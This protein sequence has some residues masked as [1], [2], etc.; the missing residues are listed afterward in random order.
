MNWKSKR[1][2]KKF[3]LHLEKKFSSYLVDLRFQKK[4]LVSI[5]ENFRTP[6]FFNFYSMVRWSIKFK[7][8]MPLGW[9]KSEVC[10]K[11]YEGL[12]ICDSILVCVQIWTFGVQIWTFILNYGY[13]LD[14]KLTYLKNYWA[15]FYKWTVVEIG[16]RRRI[17]IW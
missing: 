7:V 6:S 14:F 1:R 15:D 13:L 2:K 5:F 10:V 8:E 9:L 16:R 12:K 4:I 17:Q 11:S 3:G